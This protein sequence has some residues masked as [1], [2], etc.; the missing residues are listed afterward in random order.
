MT[1][2]IVGWESDFKAA[3]QNPTRGSP[4]QARIQHLLRLV[5]DRGAKGVVFY[6]V[7]FCEPEQ[8][9]VPLLRE[10]L[11]EKGVPSIALEVDLSAQ[12]PGQTVTRLEAFVE[13]LR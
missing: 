1:S 10:A 12:L 7:K 3:R 11:K 5:R 13:M 2:P 9:D 4:I 8:F 6:D